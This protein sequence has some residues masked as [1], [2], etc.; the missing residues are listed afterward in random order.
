MRWCGVTVRLMVVLGVVWPTIAG[1]DEPVVAGEKAQGVDAALGWTPWPSPTPLSEV[2]DAPGVNARLDA[3]AEWIRGRIAVIAG[4]DP[5]ATDDATRA[6]VRFIDDYAR[7]ETRRMADRSTGTM[8]GPVENLMNAG[9][10]NPVLL[11]LSAWDTWEGRPNLECELNLRRAMVAM[12]DRAW[13]AWM[14]VVI[15]R[16]MCAVS[17]NTRAADL[18]ERGR[19]ELAKWIPVMV[20]EE[21]LGWEDTPWVIEMFRD[22]GQSSPDWESWKSAVAGLEACDGGPNAYLREMLLGWIAVDM[23]WESRTDGWANEVSEEQWAGFEANLARARGHLERAHAMHPEL[24]YAAA[25]MVT[26]A[27]GEGG[28]GNRDARFWFDQ[29]VRAE[30]D[31]KWAYSAYARSLLPRW[32]GSLE[33]M[34][35]FALECYA[36][37]RFDTNAPFHAL[38]VLDAMANDLQYDFSIMTRDEEFRDAVI[39]LCERDAKRKNAGSKD[40]ESARLVAMLWWAEKYE[41]LYARLSWQSWKTGGDADDRRYWR[42]LDSEVIADAALHGMNESVRAVV[43]A[44]DELLRSGDYDGAIAKVAGIDSPEFLKTL[45]LKYGDLERLKAGVADRVALVT[46]LR[47]AR[48]GGEIPLTPDASGAGW[49]VLWG[50]LSGKKDALPGMVTTLSEEE[51]AL[52]FHGQDVGIHLRVTG[53]INVRRLSRSE[54]SPATIYLYVNPWYRRFA[55]AVDFDP[56]QQSIVVRKLWAEEEV[57]KDGVVLPDEFRFEIVA[58]EGELAIRV[59][60]G[61]W[62]R[63]VVP[64]IEAREMPGPYIGIGSSWS[65]SSRAGFAD[66]KATVLT[67]FPEELAAPE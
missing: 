50:A 23:A 26:V 6:S 67:E 56:K 19:A 21:P 49:R 9:V 29:A 48:A 46:A 15:G 16:G 60:D 34:R 59:E 51:S 25:Q 36:T 31:N 5:T 28:E 2:K 45:K 43:G 27:M 1:A 30:F 32:G 22:I 53:R 17:G 20:C 38:L 13:P 10:M 14:H 11:A 42:V 33:A 37:G 7:Y 62:M 63:F 4:V 40:A 52:V 41:A 39:D 44:S 55:V 18:A 57:R 64:K 8:R 12:D 47:G 24:P 61:A 35:D 3:R 66:L 54:N 65:R 58:W